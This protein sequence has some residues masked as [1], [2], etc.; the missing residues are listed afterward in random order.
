MKMLDAVTHDATR[1]AGSAR[2]RRWLLAL[3]VIPLAAG[4][5]LTVASP[6]MAAVPSSGWAPFASYSIG[7]VEANGEWSSWE[8]TNA[9]TV[10]GDYW[11]PYYDHH[12]SLGGIVQGSPGV[13]LNDAGL[14]HV[15]VVG[16]DNAVYAKWETI[17]NTPTSF[18]SSWYK[19]G[20]YCTSNP[21]AF[22]NSHS[23]EMELFC[24]GSDGA[25]YETWQTSP[26]G[27]W[28]NWAYIGGNGISML[29]SGNL[30]SSGGAFVE[31]YGTDG[32]LYL[33]ERPN[34]WST[35]GAWQLA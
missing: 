31:M 12:V 1:K 26:G 33:T 35:W 24:R 8:A 34:A 3:A 27:T 7:L 19:L 23:H 30:G 11:G 5:T 29:V 21:T 9:G 13:A 17:A 2:P 10:T 15:F 32:R 20:G 28:H 22:L 6:A 14:A 4:L 18:R 25:A 16:T